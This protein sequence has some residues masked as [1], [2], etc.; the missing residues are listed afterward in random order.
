MIIMPVPKDVRSF[1]PK[2]IGPFSKREFLGV[3]GMVL[4]AVITFALT[5]PFTA[6]MTITQRAT[7]VLIPG[8]IPILCVFIDVQGMPIWVFAKDLI[9]QKFIAPRHRLYKVRNLYQDYAVRNQITMEYLD[10]NPGVTVK[11]KK[12]KKK[13]YEKSA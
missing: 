10:D 13:E 9:V 12:K 6:A 1:K 5:A 7:I 2:F 11:Q 8:V 3:V 4:I